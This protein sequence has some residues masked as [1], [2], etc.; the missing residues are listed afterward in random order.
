MTSAQ[1]RANDLLAAGMPFLYGMMFDHSFS[2][3]S[4]IRPNPSTVADSSKITTIGLHSRHG[5]ITDVG[6]DIVAEKKCISDLLNGREGPCAVYLMSD[7][8]VTVDLLKHH[9]EDERMCATIVDTTDNGNSTGFAGKFAEHGPNP[10]GF[11][12]EL[13]LV[14]S[15][16]DGFIGIQRSSS[17][18]L[19][20]QMYY[21]AIME[22]K[23]APGT[24][25]LPDRERPG[26]KQGGVTVKAEKKASNKDKDG[27]EVKNRNFAK[28][29]K[30]D[31]TNVTNKD[32]EVDFPAIQQ[33]SL[34]G[35][36]NSG[37]RWTYE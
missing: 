23:P 12:K 19:E 15:A 9:V 29:S 16:R 10:G 30:P 18:L 1:E 26:K 21:H 35:E 31:I 27:N 8:D 6:S 34:L 7:R 25:Y 28:K 11:W 36:R 20:E 2:Y 13:A 14:S 22:G 5:L 33:I 37:T 3:S 17:K 32:I 4:S 24:C